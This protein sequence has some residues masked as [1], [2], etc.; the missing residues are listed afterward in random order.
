MLKLAGYIGSFFRLFAPARSLGGPVARTGQTARVGAAGEAL[1]ERTLRKKGYTIIGR[2]VLTRAGEADLVC[3]TPDRK[4]MV[5]VEVKAR[6]VAKSEGVFRPEIAVNHAKRRKLR[7]I[8]RLLAKANRWNN[9]EVR[10]DVVAIEYVGD[11][12]IVRH[13]EGIMRHIR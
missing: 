11:Q 7:A 9:V 4:A 1:A 5:I 8:A 6:H 2:N 10:V 12:A 3:R 13:H